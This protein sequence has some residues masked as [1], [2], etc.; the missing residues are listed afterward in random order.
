MEQ[1]VKYNPEQDN[2]GEVLDLVARGYGF[3]DAVDALDLRPRRDAKK[4]P[5]TETNG[6]PSDTYAQLYVSDEEIVPWTE[7]LAVR[8]CRDV[9]PRVQKAIALSRVIA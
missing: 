1:T 5:V 6:R 4:V 8:L 9:T 7:K 3:S 2:V